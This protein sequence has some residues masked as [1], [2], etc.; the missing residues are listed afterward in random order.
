MSSGD[1]GLD[2]SHTKLLEIAGRVYRPPSGVTPKYQETGLHTTGRNTTFRR[3]DCETH[4]GMEG[5]FGGF[6]SGGGGEVGIIR[7]VVILMSACPFD[8]S[9]RREAGTSI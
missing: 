3:W 7:K 9:W 1:G 5:I 2:L 8:T 4:T 6:L